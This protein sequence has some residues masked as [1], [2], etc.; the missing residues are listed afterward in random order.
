MFHRGHAIMLSAKAGTGCTF[1][2]ILFS[3][4]RGGRVYRLPFAI[5]MAREFAKQFYHSQAW[6]QTQAAYVKQA[7]GLCERCLQNGLI[8]AGVIVHHKIHLT[9]ENINDPDVSLND[10][11]LMLLCRDCHA[12]EH[13]R[14]R[15]WK[16]DEFGRVEARG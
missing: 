2:F 4:F 3:P 15:R 5:D 12:L 6:K 16:V 7:G 13:K 1:F 11:N 14:G 9:P 10:D 8:T